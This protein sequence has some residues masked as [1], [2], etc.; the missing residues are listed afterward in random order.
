[1]KLIATYMPSLGEQSSRY[2]RT[3]GS[4]WVFPEGGESRGT[5]G[6][7]LKASLN[8]LDYQIPDGVNSDFFAVIHVHSDSVDVLNELMANK[9]LENFKQIQATTFYD[10]FQCFMLVGI[11][12]RENE[13]DKTLIQSRKTYELLTSDSATS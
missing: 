11:P 7:E 1:M 5:I 13:L 9:F 2:Q 12:V 3:L 8:S 10:V 4:F 6:I